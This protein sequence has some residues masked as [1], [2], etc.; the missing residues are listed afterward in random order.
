M[1]G[2]KN[3]QDKEFTRFFNRQ[4]AYWQS[5]CKDLSHNLEDSRKL[6]CALRQDNADQRT[7][8]HQAE[9]RAEVYER[10]CT[11]L[12]LKLEEVSSESKHYRPISKTPAKLPQPT[13]KQYATLPPPPPLGLSS[14]QQESKMEEAV[15][16]TPAESL[17]VTPPVL[18][19]IKSNIQKMSRD[20]K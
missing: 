17:H 4:I 16:L 10:E 15:P 18:Q 3:L 6:V 2:S 12:K 8:I 7:G 1:S 11:L 13:I 14:Q 5:H 20:M 9:K 19:P